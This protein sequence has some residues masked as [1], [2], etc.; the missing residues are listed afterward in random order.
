V[1]A[2]IIGKPNRFAIDYVVE[3][4]GLKREECVMI[5]DNLETD[6]LLGKAG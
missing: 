6:V 2:E 1:Q 4:N 5:G 3:Q